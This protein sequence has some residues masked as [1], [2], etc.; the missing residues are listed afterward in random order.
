MGLSHAREPF[1]LDSG[2]ALNLSSVIEALFPEGSELCPGADF[3]DKTHI[4]LCVREREQILGV[5]RIPEWQREELELPIL[6]K[7]S[8]AHRFRL[9][10]EGREITRWVLLRCVCFAGKQF[11]LG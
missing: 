1:E 3:R 6:Y 4:Q 5:F 8:W 9:G 10:Q 2:H 11:R 7:R